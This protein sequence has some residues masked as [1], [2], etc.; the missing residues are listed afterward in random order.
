MFVAELYLYIDFFKEQLLE[1][2]EN[3]QY[4]KKRKFYFSFCQNLRSGI[5]YYKGLKGLSDETKLKL[6]KDLE[7]ASLELDYLNYQYE[8][9]TNP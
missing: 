8:I 6:D 4:E 1:D 2:V 7:A 9:I 3:E 5:A